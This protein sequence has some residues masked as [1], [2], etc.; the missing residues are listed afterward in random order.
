MDVLHVLHEL[1]SRHAQLLANRAA[2][3]VWPS[4]QRGVLA[5]VRAEGGLRGEPLPADVA[6]EGAVLEALRLGVVVAQVLLQVA[7][8]YEGPPAVGEVASVRP[9]S[10]VE[11]SVLLNVGKLLEA[12]VAVR[13]LVRLLARVDADVLDKLEVERK[14]ENVIML[15]LKMVKSLSYLVI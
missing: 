15:K 8:L 14:G 3:R 12:A 7:Q 6:V 11:A 2:A 13:A 1:L 9:L 4:H 10:R 5:V